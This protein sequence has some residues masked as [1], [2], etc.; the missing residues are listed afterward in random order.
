M[1]W[2]TGRLGGRETGAYLK[3]QTY[4]MIFVPPTH[5]VDTVT[6]CVDSMVVSPRKVIIGV[7]WEIDPLD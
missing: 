3:H 7:H 5:D 6:C 2:E 1:Y 4:G